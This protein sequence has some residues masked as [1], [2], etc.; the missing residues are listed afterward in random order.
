[1]LGELA[2]NLRATAPEE[3]GGP[4]ILLEIEPF[5]VSQDVA[6]AVAFLLTEIIE[7]ALANS[8]S[9]QLRLSVSATDDPARATVRVSSPALI[10]SDELRDLVDT[11]YGRVMEGLS[12]QLRSRLHHDPLVGAY[13]IGVAVL[14][15]D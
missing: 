13:E 7:L 11:R 14:G 2:S 3:G 12:R 1:V 5:L 4:T 10:D 15:R 6:V 9:A 8:S